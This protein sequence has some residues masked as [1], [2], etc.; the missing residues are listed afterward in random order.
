MMRIFV[1]I[2]AVA[3]LGLSLLSCA[4]GGDGSPAGT[5]SAKSS[6]RSP[7]IVINVVAIDGA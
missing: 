4:G 6:V 7:A 3:G 2:F 5:T 1:A